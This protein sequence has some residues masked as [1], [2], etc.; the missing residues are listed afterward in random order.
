MGIC[1]IGIVYAFLGKLKYLR[2]ST[3][4][5]FINYF[6]SLY[7]VLDFFIPFFIWDLSTSG[8]AP[9]LQCSSIPRFKFT[10]PVN[11]SL[12]L[13]LTTPILMNGMG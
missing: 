5:D 1:S 11:H 4:Y 7:I 8:W 12:L 10:M 9:K 6:A 3:A 13:S 2:I